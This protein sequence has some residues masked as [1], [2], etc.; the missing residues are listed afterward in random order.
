VNSVEQ[1]NKEMENSVAFMSSKF[2]ENCK[3]VD[4]LSV[5]I[6]AKCQEQAVRIEDIGLQS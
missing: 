5:R 6:Q 1:K 4:D 3:H 2:D